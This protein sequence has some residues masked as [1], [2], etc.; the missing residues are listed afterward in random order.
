MTTNIGQTRYGK[1]TNTNIGKKENG[2][3]TG[4]VHLKSYKTS[5]QLESS[6]TVTSDPQQ[7]GDVS[8]NFTD[9][10]LQ[11]DTSFDITKDYYVRIGIPKSDTY[12]YS[13]YVKLT[14]SESDNED[15]QF[16]EN[17]EVSKSTSTSQLYSVGICKSIADNCP[18]AF[19]L[20][21]DTNDTNH[22]NKVRLSL[23]PVGSGS[24]KGYYTLSMDDEDLNVNAPYTRSTNR[25][26]LVKNRVYFQQR[27]LKT[28]TRTF[29][30]YKFS[31]NGKYYFEAVNNFNTISLTAP[32]ITSTNDEVT[33]IEFLFRPVQKGFDKVCFEMVRN[34]QDYGII[35]NEEVATTG[36]IQVNYGRKVDIEKVTFQ[37]WSLG[38][39][40][41]T[42]SSAGTLKKIGVWGRPE[43]LM[44]ING[45]QILIGPSGYYELQNLDVTSLSIAAFDSKD[46]YTVDYIYET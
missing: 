26:N 28:I 38:N 24:Y 27:G 34:I 42:V 2:V 36:T 20:C 35:T 44:G 45:E 12:D 15:Y 31:T 46:A 3:T 1:T 43:L 30:R 4:S 5:F 10:C 41:D 21:D 7:S 6:T 13:F 9:F 22:Y 40:V 33:I 39:I 29:Y 19:I 18:D 17:I 11:S 32:W 16:I 25:V 8:M 37:M 14:S 23:Q